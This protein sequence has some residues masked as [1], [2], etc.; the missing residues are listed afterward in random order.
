M[1]SMVYHYHRGTICYFLFHGLFLKFF[2]YN[3]IK[4]PLLAKATI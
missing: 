2:F 3:I 4:T 1:A